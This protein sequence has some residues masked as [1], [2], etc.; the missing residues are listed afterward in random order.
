MPEASGVARFA[1]E[2][3]FTDVTWRTPERSGFFQPV[4]T[5]RVG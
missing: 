2:A 5:A 3:G 4:L 1:V